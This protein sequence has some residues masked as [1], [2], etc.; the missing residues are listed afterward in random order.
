MPRRRLNCSRCNASR[1]VDLEPGQPLRVPDCL[2][3]G[4]EAVMEMGLDFSLTQLPQPGVPR[5][6]RWDVRML[7]RSLAG[8]AGY[9]KLMTLSYTSKGYDFIGFHGC[10]ANSARAMM[11][12][13]VD[14]ARNV[15]GA[16]GRGFYVGSL[17]TGIPADWATKA[18]RKGHGKATRLAVYVKNFGELTWGS[19]YDWGKMDGDDEVAETGLEIVFFG[20]AC[21]RLRVVPAMGL[22]SSA[23]WQACP[24]DSLGFGE[25]AKV[26]QAATHLGVKEAD[27]V[28]WICKGKLHKHLNET[29]LAWLERFFE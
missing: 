28:G 11:I 17:Y 8:S 14:P 23:L 6:D 26:K 1:I 16:R 18:E 4:G 27:L 7:E 15:V 9:R 2:G 21:K 20:D 29:Q 5:I 12:G 25:R 24:Q 22:E 19:D 10:G 13:G 3:C